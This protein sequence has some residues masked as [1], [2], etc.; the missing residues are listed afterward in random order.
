MYDTVS[1]IVRLAVKPGELDALI[2][3]VSQIASVAV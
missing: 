2:L 3:R 1:W